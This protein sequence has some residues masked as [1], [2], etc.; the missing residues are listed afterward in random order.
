MSRISQN[1]HQQIHFNDKIIQILSNF[2]NEIK[3]N[4]SNFE[5]WIIHFLD[6]QNLNLYDKIGMK[7]Y[8]KPFERCLIESIKCY[9]NYF[10]NM[11]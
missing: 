10:A 5:I 1:H 6:N 9:H 7:M 11:V 8:N 2:K 3:S 4:Y